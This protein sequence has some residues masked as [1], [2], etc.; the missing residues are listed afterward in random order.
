LIRQSGKATEL[1]AR[2]ICGCC[3]A[4]LLRRKTTFLRCVFYS[5]G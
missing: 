2:S 3:A 1:A 4:I 5:Q